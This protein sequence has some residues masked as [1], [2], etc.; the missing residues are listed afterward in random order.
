MAIELIT[1]HAGTPHV[2][3]ADAG[4]LHAGALGGG[5]YFFGEPPAVSM[6]DANTAVIGACEVLMHGRH[7]RITQPESLAVQSGSQSGWRKDVVYLRYSRD[8]DTGTESVSLVVQAG[9]PAGTKDAAADKPTEYSGASVLDGALVVDAPLARVTIE[10]LA[11]SI[12]CV[13]EPLPSLASVAKRLTAAE[14]AH[15]LQWKALWEGDWWGGKAAG[16]SVGERRFVRSASGAKLWVF[17]WSHCVNT[18]GGWKTENTG[19]FSTTLPNPQWSYGSGVNFAMSHM[20]SNGGAD[21]A[22]K[23]LYLYSDRMIGYVGNDEGSNRTFTL[24]GV[25]AIY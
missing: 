18:D 23:Y 3:G 11:P 13:L 15:D 17:L 21:W 7:V 14:S 19:W 9:D 22:Y 16:G 20:R 1:G 6:Q 12:E 5:A 4:A 8:A 25:Y 2:S 10:G 24:R